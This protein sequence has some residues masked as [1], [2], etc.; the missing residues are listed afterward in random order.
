MK[1]KIVCEYAT[2]KDLIDWKTKITEKQ[3][4][5]DEF[6]FSSNQKQQ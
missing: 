1:N 5:F 3:E 6:L 2:K 4:I